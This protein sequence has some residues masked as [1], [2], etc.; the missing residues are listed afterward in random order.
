MYLWFEKKQIGNSFV[1]NG[2]KLD[3]LT[4]VQEKNAQVTVEKGFHLVRSLVHLQN[5]EQVRRDIGAWLRDHFRRCTGKGVVDPVNKQK[6]IHFEGCVDR[7]EKYEE[8]RKPM[9]QTDIQR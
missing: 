5:V 1:Q 9:T 4:A 3:G 7:W 6:R 2:K 8:Y